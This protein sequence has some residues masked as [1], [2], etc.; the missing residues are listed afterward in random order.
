MYYSISGLSAPPDFSYQKTATHFSRMGGTLVNSFLFSL[1]SRS[2][3]RLRKT[4]GD[5]FCTAASFMVIYPS[6][7]V[8]YSSQGGVT[9]SRA[10]GF[11]STETSARTSAG[12]LRMAI[13]NVT[14]ML[15]GIKRFFKSTPLDAYREGGKKF[16]RDPFASNSSGSKR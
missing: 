6:S 12:I 2:M 3:S 7:S 15:S 5:I 9:G 16:L 10:S 4:W 14:L 8:S 11:R 13:I 1:P